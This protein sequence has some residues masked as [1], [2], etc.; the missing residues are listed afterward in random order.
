MALPP[1]PIS[2]RILS[3]VSSISESDDQ[4]V[5]EEERR[6]PVLSLPLVRLLQLVMILQNGRFPNARRLAEACAVSRRTIYRDLATLEAAGIPVVYRADR[7][8]YQ[9]AGPG[10]LQPAPLDDQ[11]ALAILL[12][13]RLCP[14][15]HPLGSL[16]PVQSGVDKVIQALPEGLRERIMLGGELLTSSGDPAP[17]DRPPE[18][19]PVYEAIWQA[20]RQRRQMRL[21]YRDDD[22]SLLTTKVSLYRITSIDSCW[23]VVGRSTLHR[24]VRLFRIPWIQRVEVTEESYVIPP[25]F[26][27]DRWLSQSSDER[28]GDTPREV[29]LRFN[30]RIAPVVQDRHGRIGQKLCHLSSGELDLFLTVP[31]RE[32]IVLWILGFGEQ[33]E[34]LKP[35]ELRETV[36]RR[37]EQIARIHA[38]PP[39]SPEAL[40][41]ARPARSLPEAPVMT[42]TSGVRARLMSSS[43]P[44]PPRPRPRRGIASH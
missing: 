11:E 24:G 38:H 30:A 26:R 25:R 42:T 41:P 8:G 5:R 37:A 32:E 40:A 43:R 6:R 18:R 36:K 9:L 20:L 1:S 33:V 3:S 13:S 10:F 34:V 17:L 4:A 22:D 19:R 23:S 2:S 29:Q 35:A 28:P 14:S 27:L 44:H 39:G 12:L 16:R 21:W 15:D 7:Q 31:L